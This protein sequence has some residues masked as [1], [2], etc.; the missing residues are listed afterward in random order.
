[1]RQGRVPRRARR[2]RRPVQHA[3]Q[4][5][6]HLHLRLAHR[7]RPPRRGVRGRHIA[8]DGRSHR[9]GRPQERRARLRR[10]E[11]RRRDLGS[12]LQ[13]HGHLPRTHPARAAPGGGVRHDS[14]TSPGVFRRA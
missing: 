5:A 11:G 14:G 12:G 13:Q 2:P 4:Q 6:L 7:P 3:L 8:R 9:R 10:R 1:M